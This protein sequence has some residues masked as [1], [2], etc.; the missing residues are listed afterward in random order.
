MEV[1]SACCGMVVCPLVWLAWIVPWR[2]GLF[3]KWVGPIG[4]GL[5]LSITLLAT[6]GTLTY[7]LLSEPLV[8]ASRQGDLQEVRR[9][10]SIGA[11]PDAR[12]E[13]GT[14][15]LEA[16]EGGHTEVVRAL[17]Q[18]GADPNQPDGPGGKSPLRLAKAAGHR[19]IARLL[20]QAGAR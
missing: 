8:A 4:A 17:L 10:L 20:R 18:A 2:R 9:L 14:P 1:L 19:E 11:S 12:A 5:L 7:V 6:W 15:L 13:F 3:P 16:V